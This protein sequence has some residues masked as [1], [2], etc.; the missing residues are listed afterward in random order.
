MNYID[1][2]LVILLI[3]SAIG[4]FKNGLIAEVVSL[5]ALVLGVWGAIEFSYITTEFLTE[6]LN[7]TSEH[8]GIISFVV[9]FIVIVIL[10]HI[11]GNTV[12]KLAEAA[13]LGFVNRL[14][15]MVF[16]VL[17]SALILS[18][19]LLVF[20]FIDKD[21]KILPE[22]AKAESRMYEPIKNFAPSILPF[23]NFWDNDKSDKSVD[24]KVA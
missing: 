3:L 7:I 17:K 21:V 15:G 4:G 5:A 1:I 19:I 11:V 13:M 10:V 8:L 16:S 23:I 18:I 20:D 22:K 14:A 2:I 24:G 12:N 9:T 6:K